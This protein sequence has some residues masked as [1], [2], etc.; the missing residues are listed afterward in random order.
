MFIHSAVDGY[1]S[2]FW[3]MAITTKDAVNRGF[4]GVQLLRLAL[5]AGGPCLISGQ[6]ARSH[7]LGLSAKSNKI[8]NK[9]LKKKKMTRNAS[10][11][12]KDITLLGD[13]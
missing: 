7:L 8:I 1:F 10:K 9:K 6:G 3:F 4:P 13:G 2:C 12:Y 5:S 11:S